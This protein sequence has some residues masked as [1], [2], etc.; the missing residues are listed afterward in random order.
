MPAAKIALV[1]TNPELHHRRI[2]NA[3]EQIAEGNFY[4]VNLC[5]RWSTAYDSDPWRLWLAQRQA[6]PVPFGFYFEDEARSVMGRSMECFLDWQR[7][8]TPC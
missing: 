2:K 1:S 4:Q 3:L 7:Q 5:R 6:S 8:S